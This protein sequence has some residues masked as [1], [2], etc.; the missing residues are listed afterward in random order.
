VKP[1]AADVALMRQALGL[2]RRGL[3][4]TSPNPAVGAVVVRR[5]Q[6]VGRGFTR[7]AGGPHAEV[8]AL[9]DAG[10]AARGAT[11]YV[12]LEPC[13]HHG[14]T[15]PCVDA[16]LAAGIERVVL[17]CRDPNPRVRGNGAER[18]RRAG[19]EV[20][21]GI[22]E[23]ECAEAIRFFAK[24]A[25]TGLPWA[26][27]K[28]A[29]S[30]DGRIATHDGDSRWVTGE[31]ARR[32]VHRLRNWHDAVLVGAQTVIAD[33]PALTCRL[34]GG[35]DPLRV[36]LDGRL[37]IPLGAG[38]VGAGTLVLTGRGTKASKVA[39]LRRRGV[40]VVELP[41]RGGVIAWRDA[42][43]E[44]G[45][46]GLCS[47]LVEGGGGTAATALRGGGVDEVLFFY[48]PKLVGADGQPMIG[49]LGVS[50]MA[51][52][53]ALTD[54]HWRRLGPDLLLRALAAPPAKRRE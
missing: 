19:V 10:R 50:R 23:S 28:L 21:T 47:V 32:Y 1:V 24:H 54:A 34:R 39:A 3:G 44:I 7:P 31:A 38:I 37:R 4:R 42:L 35:R 25:A 13:A 49:P 45:R 40:E 18:L 48:A 15:P 51:R 12:T 20:A 17:G 6:V 46:R 30:L 53:L 2:A 5:G 41:H 52:A 16:V 26:T 14:R 11:L 9:A 8:V 43:A 27:L 33:D 29:A 36:V 22:L